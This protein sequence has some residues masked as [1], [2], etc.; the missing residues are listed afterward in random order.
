MMT[1]SNVRGGVNRFT[2]LLEG[3]A[4]TDI[5]DGVVDV[6]VGRFWSVLQQRC[7]RHDHP[8]LAITALRNVG[9]DPGLLHLVQDAV[10]RKALDRGDLFAGGFADGDAAGPH[11]DP[12]DMDGAG[13]AL[14]N[15]AT[16]FG[17]GE[18]DVLPDCPK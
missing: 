18:A 13:P 2:H 6:L 17:A 10:D 11:R 3:A 1:S 7:D 8:A 5:G 9:V 14:C 16:V 15:A 4:A 12:V